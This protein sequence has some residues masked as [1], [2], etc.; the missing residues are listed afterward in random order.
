MTKYPS[1]NLVARALEIATRAH[2]GQKDK[3]GIDYI[4]HPKTVASFVNSDEEKATAYLHDVLEDTSLT[5]QD[6][7]EQGIPEDV[8]SAVKAMT[9]AKD[10]SYFD[11]LAVVKSNPIARVVK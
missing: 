3:A 2:A 10:V 9:H 7:R 11:Y 4:E 8:L 6:L 5:E 1:N